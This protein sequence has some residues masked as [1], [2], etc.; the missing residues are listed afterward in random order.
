[1]RY[2]SRPLKLGYIFPDDEFTR[3]AATIRAVTEAELLF[4]TLRSNCDLVSTLCFS[5]VRRSFWHQQAHG[6]ST[7]NMQLLQQLARKPRPRY[8]LKHNW[9]SHSKSVA[10]C[11]GNNNNVCQ[12]WGYTFRG[13]RPAHWCD[14]RHLAAPTS[15]NNCPAVHSVLA[16]ALCATDTTYSTRST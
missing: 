3:C 10:M 6:R 16:S 13:T 12:A 4:E 9:M 8:L 11:R 14:S 1:M 7:A 2:G 15:T 5:G